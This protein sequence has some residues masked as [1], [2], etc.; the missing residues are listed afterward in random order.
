MNLFTQAII[1]GLM[2]GA[3]Y[4]LLGI[5]LV[6]MYRSATHEKKSMVA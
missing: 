3:L 4:A 1:S 5:G 6:L 2:A